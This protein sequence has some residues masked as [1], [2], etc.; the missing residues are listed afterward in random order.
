MV[1]LSLVGCGRWGI[2][3][4]KAA[5]NL[6][7]DLKYICDTKKPKIKIPKGTIYTQ[8]LEDILSDKETE[9][10][11]IA[12]P[13]SSHYD[14][15]YKCISNQKNVLIEKPITTNSNQV[16]E[17]CKISES[18]NVVLMVGHIFEYNDAVKEI[19]RII[20]KGKIGKLIYIESRRVGLGP[21]RDDVNVLWD[22]ASHDIYI[23]NFFVGKKPSYVASIGFS[24][25]PSS[26]KKT[27]KNIEDIFCVNL[28]YEDPSVLTT[29]YVN[30][31]HPVKERQI[32]IGGE[33]KA[34]LFDDVE[35]SE[36][37]KIFN[38]RI[39]YLQTSGGFGEFQ[40]ITRE[41]DILTPK[42][43]LRA[44]LENQLNHFIDCIKKK[45]KCLTDGYKGLEVVK[46][47]E[48]AEESKRKGGL[49]IR[50]TL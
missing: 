43:K 32:I 44:P 31:L 14:I 13:A 42:I 47:L 45:T 24:N 3:Y 1:T 35:P 17:L 11:I 27:H 48:A 7:F 5:S 36:K 18:N 10:V 34:I 23:S 39:S 22:F 8:N 30:W 50:C 16:G 28:F 38:R 2:N 49:M 20:E 25:K 6:D 12:T 46:I 15:G 37:I 4:V 9:G 29:I 26:N 41:G 40:T 19:R 21:V 33:K